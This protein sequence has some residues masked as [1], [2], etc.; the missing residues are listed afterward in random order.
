MA[1]AIGGTVIILAAAVGIGS[2]ASRIFIAITGYGTAQV[3]GPGDLQA[4]QTA[5]LAVFLLTFQ[6]AVVVL[7][8]LAARSFAA[9]PAAVLAMHWPG[10]PSRRMAA[11]VGALAA[12]ALGCAGA[13]YI[14]DREALLHD[15]RPFAELMNSRTWW[16]MAIAAGIGAP[17]A[18]ELLF[19]GFMLGLLK[20]TRAGAIGATLITAV[21]WAALHANYS[22]YGLAT[23][24]LI[25]LYLGYSRLRTNSLWPAIAGHAAYNSFIVL[26]LA[27]AGDF[28]L[29]PV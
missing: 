15:L 23:I 27:T 11:S 17:I 4:M 3:L 21:S 10:A 28:V 18:E 2:V 13:V 6:V 22:P 24:F 5:G 26:A 29:R 8:V 25:G 19:R 16:L 7:T 9:M 12:I 20:D 1:L 14:L